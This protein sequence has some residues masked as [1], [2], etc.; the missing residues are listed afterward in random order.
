VTFEY[1]FRIAVALETID[2]PGDFSQIALNG[3][4]SV[5]SRH[6]QYSYQILTKNRVKLGA[7]FLQVA[8]YLKRICLRH[9]QFSVGLLNSLMCTP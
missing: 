8:R 6:G 9:L 2:F 1:W 3:I 7:S 5:L 4:V